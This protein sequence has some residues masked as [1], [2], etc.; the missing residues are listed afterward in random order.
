M[1]GEIRPFKF[2]GLFLITSFLLE[3]PQDSWE[4]LFFYFSFYFFISTWNAIIGNIYDFK[5]IIESLYSF[6]K[7]TDFMESIQFETN[8]YEPRLLF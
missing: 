5:R 7:C 4:L 8:I 6:L 1:G 3:H 2:K